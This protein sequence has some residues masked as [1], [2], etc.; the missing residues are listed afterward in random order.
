ML[1][2]R[3]ASMQYF[4]GRPV[5]LQGKQRVGIS[6]GDG[7][8]GTKETAE[9]GLKNLG[10]C[11]PEPGPTTHSPNTSLSRLQHPAKEFP[12]EPTKE[13][14]VL[15]HLQEP[16]SEGNSPCEPGVGQEPL[17]TPLSPSLPSPN[18][19]PSGLPPWGR[20]EQWGRKGPQ[21]TSAPRAFSS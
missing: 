6:G 13:V 20:G 9:A 8:E 21:C 11:I 5:A 4:S 3:S 16:P 12:R 18:P 14:P 10:I 19:E 17:P 15:E 2:L 1:A 7:G